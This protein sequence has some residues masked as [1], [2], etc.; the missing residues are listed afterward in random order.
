MKK[1]FA[2]IK[3]FVKSLFPSGKASGL[4]N[5]GGGWLSLFLFA[6]LFLLGFLIAKNESNSV[7]IIKQTKILMGTIVEIQVRDGDE[8]KAKLAISKAFDEVKRID[9][10]FSAHNE[11]S[12]VWK[13]NHG[14]NQSNLSEELIAL[15]TFS[16][17]IWR[18]S[19]GS[20]DISLGNLIDLWNFK[21]EHPTLPTKENLIENIASSG[22]RNVQLKDYN[23]IILNNNVKLDF[24][25]VAKGYAVDKAVDKL[26][27]SGVLSALVNAGGEVKG[28][29]EKWIVGIQHP[30]NR[31]ELL[32]K[33]ILEDISV[34]TS[35]D[36]E[37]YFELN[38]K[39]YHHILNP[40]T[41][42]PVDGCTSVTV[43][44]RENKLAD[45]LAT[46]IFVLGETEGM[47]LVESI[48]DVEAL[49]VNSN[50]DI[51]YSRGFN[52]FLLR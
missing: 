47:K 13:I 26:K 9:D 40:K 24:G 32:C 6:G 7:E 33:L 44:C 3:I 52:K 31:N 41:G 16:D 30:R 38:G 28:F 18:M 46:A 42:F 17:S 8:E 39:R 50:G 21:A 37:Q 19:N 14:L 11:E 12:A 4:S 22:W 43:I 48:N 15:I 20:F 1:I 35:G 2:A 25:A 23:S 5:S 29:G 10:L 34:A 49:I 51:I 45:A 27:Q 36:Y